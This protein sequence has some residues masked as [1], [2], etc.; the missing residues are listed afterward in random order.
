MRDLTLAISA[1]GIG[2]RKTK[3]SVSAYRLNL[4]IFASTVLL[5]LTYLFV[6]N[7]LATKGYE[8][9]KLDEQVRVLE[10]QQK[11]L[12]LESSDLQSINRIQTSA[13]QL[14]FVPTSNVT[15]IKDSDFALK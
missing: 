15:Y 6:V 1:N 13:Q 9:R 8:I 14:N 10:E 3:T 11:T 2:K 7:S 5:G 4:A 12:L